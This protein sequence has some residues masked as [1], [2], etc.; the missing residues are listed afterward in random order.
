MKSLEWLSV[1]QQIA[2]EISLKRDVSM[3]DAVHEAMVLLDFKGVKPKPKE[4]KTV[5][6]FCANGAKSVQVEQFEN[7]K[8]FVDHYRHMESDYEGFVGEL[9]HSGIVHYS[10][11]IYKIIVV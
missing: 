2:L 11:C 4:E 7:E 10:G 6:V 1:E 3:E 9:W 5:I 8:A